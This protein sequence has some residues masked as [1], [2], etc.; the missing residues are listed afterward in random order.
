MNWFL[1]L[2]QRTNKSSRS[3]FENARRINIKRILDAKIICLSLCVARFKVYPI[4]IRPCEIDDV[5]FPQLQ[6]Y[7]SGRCN[8][9]INDN[10]ITKIIDFG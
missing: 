5:V 4:I 7:S 6:D 2:F 9:T 8:V 1:Q 10:I 3:Q